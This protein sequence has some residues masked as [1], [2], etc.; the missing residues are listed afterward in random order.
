MIENIKEWELKDW[1]NLYTLESR[2]PPMTP[3]EIINAIRWLRKNNY[4][5]PSDCPEQECPKYRPACKIG[6]C[7]VAVGMCG[8]F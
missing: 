3:Y 6:I 5:K 2:M 4:P 7:N 8:D 1:N